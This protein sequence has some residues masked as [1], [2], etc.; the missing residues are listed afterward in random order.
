VSATIAADADF[1]PVP[2]SFRR[3]DNGY[4]ILIDTSLMKLPNIG[5]IQV[6]LKFDTSF[7][8]KALDNRSNDTRELVVRALLLVQLIGPGF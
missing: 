2:A 6:N 5:E 3:V 1:H 4:E 8:W 7:V